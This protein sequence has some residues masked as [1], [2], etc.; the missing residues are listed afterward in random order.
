MT[1]AIERTVIESYARD[2][3]T[4]WVEN[5]TVSGSKAFRENEDKRAAL[6]ARAAELGIRDEVYSRATDIMQGS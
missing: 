1:E 2:L 3:V 6:L 5:M 4:L